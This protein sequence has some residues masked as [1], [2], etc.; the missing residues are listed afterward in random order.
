ML[1][2]FE[3][4]DLEMAFGV[5]NQK[6]P[7]TSDI[8]QEFWDEKTYWNKLFSTLFFK[9]GEITNII[10]KEGVDSDKAL[11][12]I[13]AVMRSWEPKHEDK[14]AIVAYMFSQWFEN[15]NIKGIDL[16]NA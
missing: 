8:P 11:R 2:I 13:K 16:K 9:G 3:V 7:K 15:I 12:A 4:S 14:E 1:K 5:E 10:P 6:I